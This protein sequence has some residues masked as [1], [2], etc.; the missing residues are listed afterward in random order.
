[1]GRQTRWCCGPNAPAFA[2]TANG[3]RCLLRSADRAEC[4]GAAAIVAPSMEIQHELVSAGY[5]LP[6]VH[7]IVNGVPELPPR[8]RQTRLAARA[9][10][11]ESNCE[12]E[13]SMGRLWRLHWPAGA[14]LRLGAVDRRLDGD[15]PPPAQSAAMVDRRRLV[16]RGAA[17]ANRGL[18]LGD[19]VVIVGV[20]DQVDEL[21]AA[22]DLMVA[23]V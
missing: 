17:A 2:A 3:K 5:P 21:L 23:H 9:V 6:V 20:F 19:R 8:T 16:A 7:H 18:T 10:L 14:G 11:A 12:L 22:A 4:R 15:C 1:V 13:L